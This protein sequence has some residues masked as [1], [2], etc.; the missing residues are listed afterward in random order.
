MNADE[1][2]TQDELVRMFGTTM[3]IEAVN[4]VFGKDTGNRTLL[5]VRAELRRLA[6]ER[7]ARPIIEATQADRAAAAEIGERFCRWTPEQV[8]KTLEGRGDEAAIVQSFARHRLAASA[9]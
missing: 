2:I 3:P 6:A 7:D 8:Y 4:L 1:K 5:E 9:D